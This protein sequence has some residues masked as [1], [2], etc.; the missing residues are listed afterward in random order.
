MRRAVDWLESRQNADGG[1]GES[2]DSY[3]QTAPLRGPR[4]QHP[5]SRRRGRCWRCWPRA[6]CDST[7]VQ[8]GVDYLLR[9]Q[10]ADGLWSDPSFTA[11]GFP[12]VFYLKYHGYCAYFPLWALAAYRN[13]ARRQAHRALERRSASS[14][15]LA[16]EARTLG[17]R[18]RAGHRCSAAGRRQSAGGQR[19]GPSAAAAAARP[20]VERRRR[21]ARELRPGGRPRSRRCA[22]APC[23]CRAKS[24][25]ATA[26]ASGYRRAPWREQLRRARCLAHGIAVGGKLLERARSPS[27]RAAAKARGCSRAPAPAPSTWRARRS[28]ESPRRQRPAVHRAARD[29]RYAPSI[30]CRAA[31][32]AA[33]GRAARLRVGACCALLL[34]APRR[35]SARC[36][37]WRGATASRACARCRGRARGHWRALPAARSRARS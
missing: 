37:G 31:V 21:R 24:S 34:R 4:R 1:W 27:A 23:C 22:R 5:V 25:R 26:T 32:M 13:V 18:A 30:R 10:Q 16:A 28:R 17:P 6:R 19:H 9:T 29:R 36:C 3:A 12:R 8:R 15:A 20:L 7:A 11:P 2:N 35:C 14:A 33:S